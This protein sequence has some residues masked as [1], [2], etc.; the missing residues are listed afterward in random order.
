M[1]EDIVNH[2]AHYEESAIAVE[3][4]DFCERLPFCEGNALKYVFRAGK[5]N[6][7]NEL[8]DLQKAVWYLN[9]SDS[10]SALK[11]TSDSKYFEYF[12]SLIPLMRFADNQIL[13][14]AS[15]DV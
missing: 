5:K 13:R 11:L 12:V 10:N 1:T 9:K 3:P 2:P 15:S 6:G 8:T 7:A 4:I 14:S